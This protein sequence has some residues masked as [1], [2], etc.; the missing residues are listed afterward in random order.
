MTDIHMLVDKQEKVE[1]SLPVEVQ[2]T[3]N[4][5]E[6]V[7]T[8]RDTMLEERMVTRGVKAM[9]RSLRK[10]KQARDRFC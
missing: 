6:A 10:M 8:L 1:Q 3:D 2:V 5:N 9:E 7:R 4:D